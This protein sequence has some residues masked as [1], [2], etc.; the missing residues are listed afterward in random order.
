MP[1]TLATVLLSATLVLPTGMGATTPGPASR[2]RAEQVPRPLAALAPTATDRPPSPLQAEPRSPAAPTA[3]DDPPPTLLPLTPAPAA[4]DTPPPSPQQ[5]PPAADTRDEATRSAAARKHQAARR[6]REAAQ[7]YEQLWQTTRD[8][9]YLLDAGTARAAAGHHGAAI[10]HWQRYLVAAT[11][12]PASE[13]SKLTGKIAAARK[14]TR[15]IQLHVQ[16]SLTPSTLTLTAPDGATQGPRDPLE[17]LPAATV[18]LSLETGDWIATL[19]R[20]DRPDAVAGFRVAADAE[21]VVTLGAQIP[22]PLPPPIEPPAPPAPPPPAELTIT[23]GP[24]RMLA[25]GATIALVGPESRSPRHVRD[26]TTTWQLAPGD[27]RV[28]VD[29]PG[30]ARAT[31]STVLGPGAARGKVVFDGK[32][33]CASCHIPEQSFTDSNLGRLHDPSET[34]MSAAYALRTAN[35]RYRTSPLRGI[36]QHPP[37]FHDGSAATLPDVVTHYN[38]V[39]KLNLSAQEQADLVEYLKSL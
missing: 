31:A 18:D 16:G 39:L 32:A 36:W 26:A 1:T 29:S 13:R 19:R 35:K 28:Q 5:D 27:W 10:V 17:L 38:G 20:P 33:K 15:P 3:T 4:T 12:V 23:L 9:R 24:D 34:G 2:P 8:P 6:H 22:P 7:Q 14:R 21:P 25:R 37:Y 11:R 30:R